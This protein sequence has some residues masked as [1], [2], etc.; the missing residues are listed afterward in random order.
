MRCG[1]RTALA[2]TN[3]RSG[4]ALIVDEDEFTAACA[5][6][7][8]PADE[9]T[10]ARQTADQIALLAG[11][12]AAPFADTGARR[13]RAAKELGLAPIRHLP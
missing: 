6:G 4:D 5:G 11:H 10:A 3:R 7:F 1:R 12:G 8:I 2:R 9:A 13:L